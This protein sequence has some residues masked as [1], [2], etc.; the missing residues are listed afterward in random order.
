MKYQLKSTQVRACTWNYLLEGLCLAQT[1]VSRLDNA[2]QHV[3]YLQSK[4]D[5]LVIIDID[6]GG[7]V[8]VEHDEKLESLMVVLKTLVADC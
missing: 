5:P 3:L 2:P 1:V 7:R 8:D 4:E 6:I